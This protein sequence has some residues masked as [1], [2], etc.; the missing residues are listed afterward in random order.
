MA[1]KLSPEEWVEQT[2]RHAASA[3]KGG[4]PGSVRLLTEK[5]DT[6]LDLTPEL[7]VWFGLTFPPRSESDQ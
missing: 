2:L 1:R 6:A 7:G 5:H 4:S 3:D